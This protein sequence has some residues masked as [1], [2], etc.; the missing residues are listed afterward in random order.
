VKACFDTYYDMSMDPNKAIRPE[1]RTHMALYLLLVYKSVDHSDVKA[2]IA[3][4]I[5]KLDNMNDAPG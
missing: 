3:D 4:H 2:I 5:A 1:S